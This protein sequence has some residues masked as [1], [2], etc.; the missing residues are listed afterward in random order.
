MNKVLKDLPFTIAYLDDI[1]IYSKT[2]REHLNHV[3][4]VFYKLC[5]AELSMKLSKC[6]FFA[7]EIQY[8]GHVLSNA[9]MKPLPSEKQHLLN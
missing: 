5:D 1:N 9:C 6:H 4:Q 8:L 7:R 3:Q 2:A